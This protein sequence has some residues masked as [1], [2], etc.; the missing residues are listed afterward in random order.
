[1]QEGGRAG[2]IPLPSKI[3]ETESPQLA[4]TSPTECPT[5]HS[6]L[7]P[8][9]KA[10]NRQ[11][12][13]ILLHTGKAWGWR[14]QRVVRGWGAWGGGDK[15]RLSRSSGGQAPPPPHC[16]RPGVRTPA[17]GLARG[18]SE[19]PVTWST[20]GLPGSLRGA[21]RNPRS[22]LRERRCG[23]AAATPWKPQG[24]PRTAARRQEDR[25][26]REPRP[27]RPSRDAG[28]EPGRERAAPRPEGKAELAGL[29]GGRA[30]PPKG[31]E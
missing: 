30:W 28:V 6:L 26:R 13:L 24:C 18:R 4:K 11:V 2:V 25:L 3:L 20:S 8:Q 19:R 9:V 12:E 1:M 23:A 31:Q 5:A 14:R 21:S 22:Y 27:R 16:P 10:A 17:T 29:G 7:H 15:A